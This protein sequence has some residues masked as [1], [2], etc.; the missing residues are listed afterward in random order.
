MPSA[1]GVDIGGTSVKLAV[2]RPDGSVL[3]RS[4]LSTQADDDPDTTISRIARGVDDL[5][6]AARRT[7]PERV[8]EPVVGVGCAGLISTQ[9]GV[10]HL[11]P[12]LPRWKDVPL[13]PDLSRRLGAP[14]LLH[15]DANAFVLGEFWAGAGRGARVL[16][17]LT[18]GTGVG[19]GIVLDGELFTGSHGFAGE[20]GHTP[21]D[22]EGPPCGCGA[23]GCLEIYVGNRAI[24]NRYLELCSGRPGP[25]VERLI[26]G[27]TGRLDPEIISRGARAGDVEARDAFARTGA[28]LGAGLAGL[29]NVFD[30]DRIVIG[31]GVAL[32][33]ELLLEPARAALAGRAM[34]PAAFLPDVRPAALGAQ[35]GVVGVA[36]E[37]LDGYAGP[38]S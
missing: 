27:D 22:V 6:D 16:L 23:R 13:G 30:P 1:V 24:V 36:L 28:L 11:S 14:V 9:E 34:A 21:I 25:H 18:L 37:A 33:G 8:G 31:G 32:A 10:V 38:G 15:N 19:G 26:E 29:A 7:D 35:A 3:L 17:G 12:N 4:S 2:V 20:F 5:L